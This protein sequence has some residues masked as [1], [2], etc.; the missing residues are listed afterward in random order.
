VI[1][2]SDTG[3]RYREVHVLIDDAVRRRLLATGLAHSGNGEG[4]AAVGARGR[5]T[6]RTCIGVLVAAG[7]RPTGR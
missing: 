7:L 6:T 5:V 3:S 4:V 1:S 2:S